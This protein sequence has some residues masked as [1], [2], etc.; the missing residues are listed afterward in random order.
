MLTGPVRNRRTGAAGGSPCAPVTKRSV[1]VMTGKAGSWRRVPGSTN[2]I[3]RDVF[4]KV[5]VFEDPGRL[6]I[7]GRDE[8]NIH[9]FEAGR[10]SS[11][12]STGKYELRLH[13]H[14]PDMNISL[15]KPIHSRGRKYPPHSSGD[16]SKPMVGPKC[17][18]L[19][20]DDDDDGGE[21]FG[22]IERS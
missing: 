5:T 16:V 1:A 10:S 17:S 8:S 7:G 20:E 18:L 11:S 9:S 4:V 12:S 15:S 2:Q 6:D 14:Q 22:Y 13:I 19:P 3:Q 21:H